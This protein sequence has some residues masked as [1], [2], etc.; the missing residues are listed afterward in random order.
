MDGRSRRAAALAVLATLAGCTGT[1]PPASPPPS[2]TPPG[3][4]FEEAHARVPLA[5]TERLALTWDTSAVP[6]TEAVLAARRGLAV[7]YWK[8]AASD[9][10]P[11]VA[12]GKPLYTE[13]FWTKSLAPY[14]DGED[15]GAADSGQL[16]IRTL[17]VEEIRP[18]QIRVVFC[19]D[20]GYLREQPGAPVPRPDR[21]MVE[22]QDMVYATSRDGTPRWLV[23]GYADEHR[24]PAP[25]YRA[26]CTKWAVHRP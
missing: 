15:S 23:A 17:A 6:D 16:W 22:S 12:A 1:P 8:S 20:A 19:T 9:W 13:W 14:D 11:I 3:L 7:K 18:N 5:G 4:G 24:D 25:G 21:A 26:E 10:R 2:S